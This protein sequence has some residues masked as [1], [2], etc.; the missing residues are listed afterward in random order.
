M[1]TAIALYLIG[2]ATLGFYKLF[3]L[4]GDNGLYQALATIVFLVAALIMVLVACEASIRSAL[5]GPIWNPLSCKIRRPVD[6]IRLLLFTPMAYWA[7]S[8]R[9]GVPL[10]PFVEDSLRY[11]IVMFPCELPA[12]SVGMIIALLATL[13]IVAITLKGTRIHANWKHLPTTVVLISGIAL[14]PINFLYGTICLVTY[15]WISPKMGAVNR[16]IGLFLDAF[17]LSFAGRSIYEWTKL[18]LCF[19]ERSETGVWLTNHSWLPASVIV[20]VCLFWLLLERRSG[21]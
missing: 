11:N 21:Q 17:A 9:T 10:M 13:V 15:A 8:S 19:H 3:A 1:Q 18:F 4:A 20:T 5:Y 16:H 7:F 14:L 12:L 6:G 2:G